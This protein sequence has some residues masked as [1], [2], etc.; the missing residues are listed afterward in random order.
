DS[1]EAFPKGSFD[2]LKL[3]PDEILT[4][5]QGQIF[6]WLVS[7]FDT[8]SGQWIRL[9]DGKLFGTDKGQAFKFFGQDKLD[10]DYVPVTPLGSDKLTYQSMWRAYVQGKDIDLQDPTT[11]PLGE[12][13]DRLMAIPDA[14]YRKLLAAYAQAK[15]KPTSEAFLDAAVMRK[16]QL[17]K[18]FAAFWARAQAERAKHVPKPKPDVI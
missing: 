7:N 11:G 6:D 1:K 10:W 15:G 3:T 5:Q 16:Q 8:H 14:E 13:I 2:P 17:K 9:A 4:L 18:D 12:Y